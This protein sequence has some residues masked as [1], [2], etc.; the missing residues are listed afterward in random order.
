MCAGRSSRKELDFI[1]LM[2]GSRKVYPSDSVSEFWVEFYGP[3]NTPYEDGV[4]FIHVQLPL[5]YPFKS[6]SIGFSNPIF[7]PNV[8]ESSG[9]VCLDVINQTW[10][11]MYELQNIFDLFLPHLLRY[12]NPSDPLNSDAG[13]RLRNDP[14]GYATFVQKHVAVYAT[15]KA[16]LETLP[17]SVQGVSECA[18]SSGESKAVS[19]DEGCSA[20]P[21]GL[22]EATA[23]CFMDEEDYEPD[24]I[25]I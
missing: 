17:L 12:P 19:S 9:S 20:T 14:V 1:K 16:A 15:R 24:A 25:D 21:Q 22:G 5:E 7:H 2:K 3:E 8:D 6:P 18:N 10:T 4:W 11:P 23:A 13:A